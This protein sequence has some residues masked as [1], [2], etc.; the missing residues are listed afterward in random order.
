MP[1]G[2]RKKPFSSKQKRQQLLDRRVRKQ[3]EDDPSA[4][5][6]HHLT[7]DQLSSSVTDAGR[8]AGFVRVFLPESLAEVE[9]A[10]LDAQRPLSNTVTPF[11]HLNLFLDPEFCPNLPLRPSWTHKTSKEQLHAKEESSFVHW[12][13]SLASAVEGDRLTF[14][15][16]SFFESNLEAYRQF[17][18][19]TEKGHVIGIVVDARCPLAYLPISLV[20]YIT[21]HLGKQFFVVLNKCDLVTE[22]HINVWRSY[23]LQHFHSCLDVFL[24]GAPQRELLSQ[25]LT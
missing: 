15:H 6:T 23:F 11:P 1:N 20:N 13:V 16:M 4:P 3:Q 12:L 14:N 18:R 7:V 17:W 8:A 22:A 5:S 25:E 24:F 9:Q 10:K 2:H 21:Q 19:S